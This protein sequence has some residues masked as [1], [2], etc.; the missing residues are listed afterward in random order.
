MTSLW[1]HSSLVEELKLSVEFG[2]DWATVLTVSLFIFLSAKEWFH[3]V[4]IHDR[5]C[6][7]IAVT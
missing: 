2:L 3:I 6:I 4:L 1:L 5:L 7:I